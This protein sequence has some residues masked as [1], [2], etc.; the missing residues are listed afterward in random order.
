M[1]QLR[2]LTLA[3]ILL[4][5]AAAAPA[6]AFD[7]RETPE[8]VTVV[9]A[10]FEAKFT[11]NGAGLTVVRGGET[12][13]EGW[14]ASGPGGTFARGA[15]TQTIGALQKV[16]GEGD[17]VVLDYATSV[18][19]SV[20][21]L[22]LR[23]F[24]DAIRVTVRLLV[25]EADMTPG[26]A[27]KLDPSGFWYGGGFQGFRD[28]Q[29]WPL[30]EASMVRP[31]FLVSGLSQATPFWYT[32]KGVACGCARR[33]ISATP[34][35]AWGRTTA[36]C[37]GHAA[38]LGARVRP[39]RREGHP[40]GGAPLRPRGGLPE[41]VPPDDYFRLPIYTTWVEHKTDVSQAKVLEYARA[42]S[43]NKLPCGVH[44]DRRQVG[45]PLRRHGIRQGQV[46]RPQGHGRRAPQA[47][48]PRHA[49]GASV[50]QRGFQDLRRSENEAAVSGRP[51][52]PTRPGALVAGHRGFVGLHQ[53]RGRARV[54]RPHGRPCRSSTASTASSSTAAMST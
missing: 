10:T 40:R 15:T 44:R 54:P 29:V 31:T 42:I 23:P 8:G 26:F 22:E 14:A 1:A 24:A 5:L 39:P 13:L 9:T 3:V 16:G 11:R 51:Q 12:V 20:A 35:T 34:S 47:G 2:R 27:W 6:A 33:S 18:K 46:P 17:V 43:A 28:P 25:S 48:L 49:V 19:D 4:F 41:T 37:G 36:C 21:R 45:D 38:R 50:R 7:V 52:R 53:S 30:N 32:T